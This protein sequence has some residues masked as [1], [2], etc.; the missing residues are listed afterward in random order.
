MNLNP[1]TIRDRCR[2][3]LN[4]YTLR[5]F[6]LIPQIEKPLILDMGM[7]NRSPD[8]GFDGNKQRPELCR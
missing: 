1:Y 5:A 6:S 8:T 4:K 3:N 7:W 2:R